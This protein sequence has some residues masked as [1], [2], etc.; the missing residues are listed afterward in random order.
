MRRWW[1][2]VLIAGAAVGFGCEPYRIE[3]WDRPEYYNQRAEGSL[4]DR[5]VLEDGTVVVNVTGAN[6]SRYEAE[7]EGGASAEAVSIRGETPGGG[8]VLRNT[9]PQHVLKNTYTCLRLEEYDVIWE[10]LLADRTRRA[11]L[12]ND[13]GTS[14]FE[15]FFREHRLELAATVNR[16]LLELPRDG[17][18][19]E[20]VSPGGTEFRLQPILTRRMEFKFTRVLVTR[21]D[22]G[23]KLLMIQ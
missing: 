3:Y 8:V 23:M 13:M 19:I 14:E 20:Q 7:Q 21:E 4:P 15:S 2:G 18:I 9:L 10:Q 11:Y 17:V 22:F 12:Q 16:I 6:R 5:V 1:S